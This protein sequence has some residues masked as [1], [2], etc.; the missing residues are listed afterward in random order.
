MSDE[1]LLVGAEE[2]IMNG[3]SELS[4]ANAYALCEAH[5][6]TKFVVNDT[7]A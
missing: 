5:F 1:V 2:A 6:V 4:Q 3:M 7:V